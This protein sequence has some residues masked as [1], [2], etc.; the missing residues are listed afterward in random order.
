M[1]SKLFII[2]LLSTLLISCSPKIRGS[3][4]L[5]ENKNNVLDA[6]EK[7]L[8]DVLYSVT[9]D[10]EPVANGKS[11]ND[12]SYEI[13][14]KTQGNYC[15]KVGAIENPVVNLSEEP[16]A[17]EAV[18]P[19]LAIG[20]VNENPDGDT[21]LNSVDPDDDND[22]VLDG[23]DN[24]PQV[25]N[26]DQKDS[27]NNNV[28]DACDSAS[29][30][31]NTNDTQTTVQHIS[32]PA[33][34]Q[35]CITVDVSDENDV[36]VPIYKNFTPTQQLN[37][38]V[39]EALAGDVINV[40]FLY[41]KSC[42]KF[43]PMFAP[44][45]LQLG[46]SWN[47]A[48]QGNTT[49]LSLD[50]SAPGSAIVQGSVYDITQDPLVE[51]TMTMIAD[52]GMMNDSETK[53]V[54]LQTTAVCPDGSEIP[55]SRNIKI[56]GKFP[57]E[58]SP[59]L[60]TLPSNITQGSVVNMD[61]LVENKGSMDL[62]DVEFSISVEGLMIDSITT[63]SANINCSKLGASASCDIPFNNNRNSVRITVAFTLPADSGGESFEANA[64]VKIND[65]PTPIEKQVDKVIKFTVKPPPE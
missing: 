52:P 2:C 45:E 48:T 8:G 46:T 50:S 60:L 58:V 30:T 15:I 14:A 10:G 55:L 5:D 54:T 56:K 26:P 65:L 25:S 28:G 53:T 23:S 17:K 7:K 33:N 57:I 20:S 41:P 39:L 38:S 43:K 16:S 31:S 6:G 35:F 47:I 12:G 42:N 22:G 1:R 59:T 11:N 29:N 36:N 32:Q 64:K 61:Y 4:F 49:P 21:L 62:N 34:K 27:N 63:N 13:V 51:K 18:A 3:I 40:D 19:K 9:A 24:C 44:P 37:Q